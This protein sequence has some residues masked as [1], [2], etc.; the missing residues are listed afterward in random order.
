MKEANNISAENKVLK[1]RKI[2]EP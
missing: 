2:K 1:I